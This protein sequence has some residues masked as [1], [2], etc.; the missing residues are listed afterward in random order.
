VRIFKNTWF[1]R[2][3][4]KEGITDGE[5]RE[6]VNQLEAE[7]AEADL[8]GGV[9]KVR[10][11]RF[12]EGKSGGYRVIVF[13]KS[14][15]RTFYVYGFAKSVKGNINEKQLRDFKRT[16]KAVLALTEKQLDDVLKTGKYLE[17]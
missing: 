2:F 5:L 4:D 3:A 9:Y 12:G 14:G 7:Q 8:G 13:F 15:K 16:A 11:A 17:I 10:V 6:M 1:A